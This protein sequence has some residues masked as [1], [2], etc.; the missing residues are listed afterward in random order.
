MYLMVL[1]ENG[2]PLLCIKYCMGNE[3]ARRYQVKALLTD[4]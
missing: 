3:E 2:N 1:V 4:G